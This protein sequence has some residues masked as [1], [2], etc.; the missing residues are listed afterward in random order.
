M[1]CDVGLYKLRWICFP[2]TCWCKEGSKHSRFFNK[3]CLKEV[4]TYHCS[5]H[6]LTVKNLSKL[7]TTLILLL[8]RLLK[9]IISILFVIIIKCFLCMVALMAVEYRTR[10]RVQFSP[11]ATMYQCQL[12]LPSRQ[13][14]LMSTSDVLA[15]CPWSCS[16]GCYLTFMSDCDIWLVKLF[17]FQ[18]CTSY[19]CHCISHFQPWMP[20]SSSQTCGSLAFWHASDPVC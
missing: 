8:C 17:F 9:I 15:P 5:S 7:W 10:L 11:A 14:Q 16:L 13:G 4:R 20:W 3:I 18:L 12:S 1:L 19:D 2:V 6:I